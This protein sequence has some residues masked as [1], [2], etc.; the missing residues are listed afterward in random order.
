MAEAPSCDPAGTAP[1]GSASPASTWVTLV[2]ASLTHGNA[3]TEQALRSIFVSGPRPDSRQTAAFL[4]H[5]ASVC[6]Y[7]S[8]RG[9]L[10]DRT[11]RVT[12][13]CQAAAPCHRPGYS[14]CGSCGPCPWRS[15]RSALWAVGAASALAAAASM[16]AAAASAVRPPPLPHC[17][18]LRLCLMDR[19]GSWTRQNLCPLSRNLVWCLMSTINGETTWHAH[20]SGVGSMCRV[21]R[22]CVTQATGLDQCRP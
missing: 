14:R 2:Y 19:P 7:C 4:L 21:S 22:V 8:A 1:A 9:S 15:E 10:R 16:P 11:T 17:L 18:H 20:I 6:S 13:P 3:L 5:L 12:R